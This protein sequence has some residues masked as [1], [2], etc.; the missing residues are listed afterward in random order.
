MSCELYDICY[1]YIVLHF[2]ALS[3]KSALEINHSSYMFFHL[4]FNL[5]VH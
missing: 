1:F 2:G 5:Q 3:V 4:Y